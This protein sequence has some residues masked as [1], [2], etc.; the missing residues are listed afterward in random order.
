MLHGRHFSMGVDSSDAG[1]ELSFEVR[2]ASDFQVV[3]GPRGCSRRP[4][5]KCALA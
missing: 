1:E 3:V 2:C 5:T 4:Q